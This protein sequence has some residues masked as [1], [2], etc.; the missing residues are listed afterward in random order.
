[1]PD[2]RPCR[3][4]DDRRRSLPGA[5]HLT[6][7]WWRLPDGRFAEDYGRGLVAPVIQTPCDVMRGDGS[8]P[9]PTCVLPVGHGGPHYG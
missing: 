3:A 5:V 7:R 1:M 9:Q 2:L 4:R 6:G 8:I